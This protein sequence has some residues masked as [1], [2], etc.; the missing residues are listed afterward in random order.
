M[1]FTSRMKSSSASGWLSTSVL[2]H[3]TATF[4]Y[5]QSRDELPSVLPCGWCHSP[6][7]PTL[8]AAPHRLASRCA[9]LATTHDTKGAVTQL[10]EDGEVSLP[11]QAGEG[12]LAPSF[13]GGWRGG[14]AEGTLGLGRQL[15]LWALPTEHLW[16][17]EEGET[18]TWKHLNPLGL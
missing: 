17:V 13:G 3:F 10:L 16:D 7:P 9:P 18:W 11:H 8:R 6:A 4:S 1:A 2:R 5:G 12:V 14:L 15:R